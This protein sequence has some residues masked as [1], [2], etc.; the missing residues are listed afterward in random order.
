MKSDSFSIINGS[1][2]IRHLIFYT[3][4]VPSF[5]IDKKRSGDN[6][7]CLNFHNHTAECLNTQSG[8]SSIALLKPLAANFLPP[9]GNRERQGSRCIYGTA[10]RP[11]GVRERVQEIGAGTD[12]KGR[13]PLGEVKEWGMG[14]SFRS[15]KKGCL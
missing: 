5:L 13:F 4:T 9:G 6:F 14:I 1:L 3:P 12:W 10:L 8:K 11:K 15:R 2:K 7:I